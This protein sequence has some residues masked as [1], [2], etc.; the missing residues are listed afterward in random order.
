MAPSRT[1]TV[2]NRRTGG[3]AN[4]K[5]TTRQGPPDG[6]VKSKSPKSRK[7]TP[8]PTPSLA[9]ILKKRKPKTYTEKELDIPKLNTI[10]PVGVMKPKG[11][12]KGKV[13]VD[14]KVSRTHILW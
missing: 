1:R 11:K 6:I 12:K 10:T 2:K 3:I 8:K 13:F 5:S 14:D 4:S 7:P 9:E